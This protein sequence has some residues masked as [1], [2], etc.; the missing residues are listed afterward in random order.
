MAAFLEGGKAIDGAL[1]AAGKFV[2]P[3]VAIAPQVFF[4]PDVDCIVW[5]D[6]QSK[7]VGEIKVGFVVGRGGKENDFASVAGQIIADS[8]PAATLAISQIVAFV[9]DYNA[10]TAKIGEAVLR[11][12]DG[13]DFG[14]QAVAV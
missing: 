5:I 3:S 14:D 2:G 13:D 10:V 7:L 1:M 9:N 12:G 6:K 4:G 8:G 11:L